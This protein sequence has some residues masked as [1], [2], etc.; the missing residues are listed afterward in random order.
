MA[1]RIVARCN[2]VGLPL[3]LR[4]LFENPT[5]ES[6][7]SV[8]LSGPGRIPV[9]AP[10]SPKPSESDLNRLAAMLAEKDLSE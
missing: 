1:I 9:Q 6:L 4:D 7:A 2:A 3:E 10:E 8:E 5:V